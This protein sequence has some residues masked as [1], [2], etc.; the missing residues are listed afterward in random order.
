MRKIVLVFV[1]FSALGF[2]QR[3]AQYGQYIYNTSNVNPAYAESRGAMSIIELYR[4]QKVGIDGAPGT[5]TFSL[6]TT[7]NNSNLGSGVS[8]VNDKIG[9]AHY[10]T[11]CTDLYHMYF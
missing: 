7:I 8:V 4:T 10:N 3:E 2:A 6:N 9:P 5:S 1:L 11:F